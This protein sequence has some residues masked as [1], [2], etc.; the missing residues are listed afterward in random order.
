[1]KVENRKWK[2][3]NKYNNRGDAEFRKGVN[4]LGTPLWKRGAGGE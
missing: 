4:L 3:E 1:M 2:I